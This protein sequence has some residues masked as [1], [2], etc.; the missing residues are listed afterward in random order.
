MKPSLRVLSAVVGVL[1][2]LAYIVSYVHIPYCP[3]FRCWRPTTSLTLGLQ[4]GTLTVWRTRSANM[5]ASGSC[6]SSGRCSFQ[7]PVAPAQFCPRPGHW[8]NRS[9]DLI[10]DGAWST[11]WG[12]GLTYR[13]RFDRFRFP[14]WILAVVP[15]AYPS[16]VFIRGPLRRWRRRRRGLCVNCA[17]NPTGNVSGVCPECGMEIKG[18]PARPVQ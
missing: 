10:W 15:L 17:Y 6:D 18:G 2:A 1:W 11:S 13:C 4:A 3:F 16:L 8:T 5:V 12:G 9:L 14:L 7:I